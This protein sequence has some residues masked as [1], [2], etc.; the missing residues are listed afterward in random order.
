MTRTF[1]DAIEA[2]RADPDDVEL[3]H[4]AR[5]VEIIQLTECV[6]G[7][8]QVASYHD[9]EVS[10]YAVEVGMPPEGDPNGDL[11]P[12]YVAQFGFVEEATALAAEFISLLSPDAE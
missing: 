6:H 12:A 3:M 11:E 4:G 10:C 2:N 8:V 5:D 9:E 7:V 1:S